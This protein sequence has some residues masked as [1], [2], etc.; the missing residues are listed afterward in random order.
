MGAE[1]ADGFVQDTRPDAYRPQAAKD[2]WN[3][4]V[5]FLRMHLGA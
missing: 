5:T 2:A 1:E 3:R 4:A